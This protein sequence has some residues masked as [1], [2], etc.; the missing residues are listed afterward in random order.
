MDLNLLNLAALTHY[1][2]AARA[3]DAAA[4]REWLAEAQNDRPSR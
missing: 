1:L 3:R 4:A 2:A